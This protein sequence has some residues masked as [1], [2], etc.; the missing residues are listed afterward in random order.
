MV[1]S[2]NRLFL[3]PSNTFGHQVN[4]KQTVDVPAVADACTFYLICSMIQMYFLLSST[5]GEWLT[6]WFF[7]VPDGVLPFRKKIKIQNNRD[8]WHIQPRLLSILLT[9]CLPF[10]RN[11]AATK[12]NIVKQLP[13]VAVEFEET[14]IP[15]CD[16]LTC[17]WL[18]TPHHKLHGT[19]EIFYENAITTFKK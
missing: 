18:N 15:P 5:L 7:F 13:I 16:L 14:S 3:E 8:W 19:K 6:D 11:S 2:W 17:C 12:D 4:T 1:I 9:T 10:P